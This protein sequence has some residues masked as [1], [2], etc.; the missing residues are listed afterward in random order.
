[1]HTDAHHLKNFLWMKDFRE[2]FWI[3]KWCRKDFLRRSIVYVKNMLNVGLWDSS[4]TM[5]YVKISWIRSSSSTPWKVTFRNRKSC[6]VDCWS[7]Y[8]IFFAPLDLMSTGAIP[9]I[10]SLGTGSLIT[11]R[12]PSWQG[13]GDCSIKLQRNLQSSAFITKCFSV[14]SS[15]IASDLVSLL[16]IDVNNARGLRTT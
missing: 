11:R 1:M 5:L 3:P 15:L 7:G 8:K 9:S 4:A 10:R 2:M 6:Q 16:N 14:K 12:K 13:E